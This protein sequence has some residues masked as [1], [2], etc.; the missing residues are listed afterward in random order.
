SFE[1]L[2]KG[3][4]RWESPDELVFSPSQP[5]LPATSFKAK[6]GSEILRWSRY[7]SIKNADD[8]NFHTPDLT[9]DNEQVTWVM[10]DDQSRMPVPQIDLHF[11]YRINPND[12]KGKLRIEV[13]EK[14]MEYN[15]QTLSADNKISVRI[16]GLART[17]DKNYE[18]RITIEKGL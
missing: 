3:R 13:D 8:I 2:I 16:S 7:S 15:L 11:N 10:T 9:L 14:P 4:F 1:P 18:A 6:L 12:L 17:E 5:L